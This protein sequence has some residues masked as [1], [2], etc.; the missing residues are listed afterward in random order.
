MFLTVASEITHLEAAPTP[1]S[2]R[3]TRMAKWCRSRS[4]MVLTWLPGTTRGR[5]LAPRREVGR[6]AVG[7]DGGLVGVELVEEEVVVVGGVDGRRRSTGSRA[8]R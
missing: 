3:W 5:G 8:R 4:A 2:P 6:G 1:T 7:V